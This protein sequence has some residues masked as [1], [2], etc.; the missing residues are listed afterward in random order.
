VRDDDD[1]D[2]DDNNYKHIFVITNSGNDP[3]YR[4]LEMEKRKLDILY[5]VS[6][7]FHNADGLPQNK[8]EIQSG[9]R[10]RVPLMRPKYV[11]TPE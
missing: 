8:K 5:T 6:D 9:A 3:R 1:D 2:D 10:P 7:H 11:R 4:Y